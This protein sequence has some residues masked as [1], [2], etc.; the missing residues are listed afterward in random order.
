[1]G[2]EVGK[3]RRVIRAVD[4]DRH[5]RVVLGGRP[6]HRRAADV[7]VVDARLEGPSRRDR[8]FERIEVHDQEVDRR[9]A[10]REHRGLVLGIG[11]ARE[12]AAMDRRVERLD[13]PVHHLGKPREIAYVANRETGIREHAARAA[14]RDELDAA[15]V[16]GAGEVQEP[17]LVGHG[18]KGAAHALQIARHG[19]LQCGSAARYHE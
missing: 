8:G 10:V 19:P 17:R 15:S 3:D 9:D 2:I 6:D 12:E 13:A 14:R 1:M 11:A 18:E 7:D 16:Q 4:H 5:V